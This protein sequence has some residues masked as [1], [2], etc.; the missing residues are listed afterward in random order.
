[1]QVLVADRVFDGD[2]F[3]GR[4]M[5]VI[6]RSRV[7]AVD[8]DANGAPEGAEVLDFG[9]ATIMPG[10]VDAHIHLAL[11]A[12]PDPLGRLSDVDDEQLL[13]EMQLGGATGVDGRGHDS[14]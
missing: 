11:D 14:A 5:V 13:A 8:T 2:R 6:D 7:V 9:D 10:L 4:A 1:M 12:G 3:L